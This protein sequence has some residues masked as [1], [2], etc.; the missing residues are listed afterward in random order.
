MN[1]FEK[2]V[3]SGLNTVMKY[4]YELTVIDRDEW[5]IDGDDVNVVLL[6]RSAHDQT[7][8]FKGSR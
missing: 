5:I 4:K 1:M 2:T 7:G 6:R 3:I 8:V